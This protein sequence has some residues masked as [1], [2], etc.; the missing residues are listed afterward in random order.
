[1]IAVF[2]FLA[3]VPSVGKIFDLTAIGG[4]H[5]LIAAGLSL[6]PTI[7]AEIGKFIDNQTN[8]REIREYRHRVIRHKIRRDDSF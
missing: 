8:I 7:V 5:W 4:Y 3:A 1:M 2:S 6:I